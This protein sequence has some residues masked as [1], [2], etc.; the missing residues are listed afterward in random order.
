MYA[1]AN[2]E[3]VRQTSNAALRI[4]E[5]QS[6]LAVYREEVLM[7]QIPVNGGPAFST[8][9]ARYNKTTEQCVL[10]HEYEL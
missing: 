2:S 4:S 9:A 7:A 3:R 8:E 6:H 1:T 5:V 10:A